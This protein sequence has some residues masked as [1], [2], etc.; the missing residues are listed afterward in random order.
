MEGSKA[1]KYKVMIVEDSS[2]IRG[3]LTRALQVDSDIEVCGVVENGQIAVD[4]VNECKPEIILLD[5]EM[6]VMDGITALPILRSRRPEAK[7][8]MISTYL[9]G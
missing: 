1:E 7:I 5:I 2:L 9:Y 3:Y 4:I 6:P 8:I